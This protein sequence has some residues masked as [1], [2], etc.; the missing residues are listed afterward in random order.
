[1]KTRLPLG[2]AEAA[3]LAG[4][5][6]AVRREERKRAR[7]PAPNLRASFNPARALEGVDLPLPDGAVRLV[8][9]WPPAALNPNCKKVH[10]ARKARFV[11]DY[12]QACWS[13]TLAQVGCD[14]GRR[15]FPGTGRIAIRLDLFPPDRRSRDDDNAESAFKAGR[16]GVADALKVDDRRFQMSRFLHIDSPRGCVVLTFNP[17]G[18]SK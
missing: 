4:H 11:R 14:A 8:L 9:P 15:L 2:M 16:D 13:E 1:M 3:G 5:V 18:D 17:T 10:P 7:K 12:R 6:K